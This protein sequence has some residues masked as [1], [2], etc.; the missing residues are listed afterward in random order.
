M[1]KGVF[2]KSILLVFTLLISFQS[3]GFESLINCY[4]TIQINGQDVR[5]GPDAERSTSEIYLTKNQYYRD[6]E[7]SKDLETLIISIF[8][9]YNGPWY[10]FSNVVVPVTKGQWNYS[11]GR[12]TYSMDEDVEYQ[13]SNY[14]RY[15]VDFLINLDLEQKEKLLSG[16][17]FFSS[18]RR[19]LFYDMEIKLEEK[20]CP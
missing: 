4:K 11:E 19:G 14:Q 12:I 16:R 5:Q 15:K 18:I 3:L 2:M 17:L 13:N 8:N 7:T 6:L 1:K 20:N 9:G 10:G